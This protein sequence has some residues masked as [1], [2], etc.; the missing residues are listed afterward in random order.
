MQ[1]SRIKNFAKIEF[2]K[3]PGE[4]YYISRFLGGSSVPVQY[5]QLDSKPVGLGLLP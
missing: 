3:E 1:V 2:K 4:T 5:F